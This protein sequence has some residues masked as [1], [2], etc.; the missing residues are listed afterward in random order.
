MEDYSKKRN[1]PS[2]QARLS[3]VIDRCIIPMLGRKK[4]QDV[5]RPDVP[6]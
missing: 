2:T 5:K 4:V 3:G 1:K 6:G